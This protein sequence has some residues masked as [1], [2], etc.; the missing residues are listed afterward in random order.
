VW[1]EDGIAEEGMVKGIGVE[2][3]WILEPKLWEN[4]GSIN[5]ESVE[6]SVEIMQCN[7]YLRKERTV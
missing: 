4:A 2:I 1:N 7:R 5:F 6:S 3:F